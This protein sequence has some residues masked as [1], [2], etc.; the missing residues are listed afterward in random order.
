MAKF[1]SVLTFV[2]FSSIAFAQPPYGPDMVQTPSGIFNEWKV[3][4]YNDEDSGLMGGVSHTQ[5]ATQKLCFYYAGMVDAHQRY[6]VV[7]STYKGWFGTATQEGDLV[8]IKLTFWNGD[9][10]DEISFD[11]TSMGARD[12]GMGHWDET[13]ETW[14]QFGTTFWGNTELRRVGKCKIAGHGGHAAN[15]FKL[16]EEMRSKMEGHVQGEQKK[17]PMGLKREIV[18]KREFSVR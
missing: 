14:S 16:A 11:L 18:E 8:R 13:V 17:S 7:S 5:W 12:R 10:N 1:L 15:E 4:Y 6:Y 3:T 2:F 9:G